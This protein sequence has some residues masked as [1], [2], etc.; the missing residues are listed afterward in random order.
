ML[1]CS[2]SSAA[3]ETP[4]RTRDGYASPTVTIK[5]APIRIYGAHH[6]SQIDG[7]SINTFFIVQHYLFV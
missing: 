5:G 7:S 2:P 3:T 6:K 4:V 1:T